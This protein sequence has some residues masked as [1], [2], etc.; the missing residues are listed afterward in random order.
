[1]KISSPQRLKVL[2]VICVI[3]SISVFIAPLSI[4]V[5]KPNSSSFPIVKVVKSRSVRFMP[6]PLSFFLT[7]NA[8]IW[9]FYGLL[10]KDGFI[11]LPNVV[12]FVFG[13]L[14]MAIY[15]VCKYS[16]RNKEDKTLEDQDKL[17]NVDQIIDGEKELVKDCGPLEG[18]KSMQDHIKALVTNSQV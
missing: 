11:W 8:L 17:T 16:F 14:Q 4:M 13:L 12:G 5:K 6:F 3:F 10:R 18:E 15:G 2:G 9:F 1:M 7:L